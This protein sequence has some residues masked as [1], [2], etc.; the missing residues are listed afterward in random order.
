MSAVLPSSMN[1]E[2]LRQRMAARE[3]APA[4]VD[5]DHRPLDQRTAYRDA[6]VLIP[7]VE[8]EQGLTVLLTKRTAHLR[9]HAGQISFP[10]GRT[11]PHDPSPVHTALRETHE[12][13]G[14]AEQHI[15]ILGTLDEYT[16]GT[17]FRITPV[18]G[19]VHQ[20][21]QLQLDAFEVDQVFELP[22][23]L[24]F[25]RR[26]HQRNSIVNNGRLHQYHAIPYREH[27]IWGATA[28]MLIHLGQFLAADAAESPL[29]P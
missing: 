25:D 4:L 21:F 6:A 10:G 5:G 14:L 8:R 17:A 13:I 28:A 22:L 12:E 24:L 11:E 26:H 27:Y 29:L 15:E 16:T 9:H 3:R 19:L 1:H 2:W 7:L 23:E 18:I 20:P